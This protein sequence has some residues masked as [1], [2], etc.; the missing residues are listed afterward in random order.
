MDTIPVYVAANEGAPGTGTPHVPEINVARELGHRLALMCTCARHRAMSFEPG[1]GYHC[2]RRGAQSVLLAVSVDLAG[3]QAGRQ[4]P[5]KLLLVML[6][7]S[8]HW[9]A[10]ADEHEQPLVSA[11]M[12]EPDVTHAGSQSDP[13]GADSASLRLAPARKKKIIR[14]TGDTVDNENMGKKSSKSAL[15]KSRAPLTNCMRGSEEAGT[16]RR[17]HCTHACTREL[18]K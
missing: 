15:P 4:L 10:A 5:F 12:L 6:Q 18:W 3:R 17:M 13:C 16:H 2:V 9:H 8:T 7:V 14:W 1:T 11:G